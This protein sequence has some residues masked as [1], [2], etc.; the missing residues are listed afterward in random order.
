MECSYL[1]REKRTSADPGP[2]RLRMGP[3]EEPRAG[4]R[5]LAEP[6]NS[7]S[8]SCAAIAGGLRN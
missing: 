7:K 3:A 6:V 2:D 5:R 8:G 1:P 4:S